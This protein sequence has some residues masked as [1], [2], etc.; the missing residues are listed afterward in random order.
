MKDSV[1]GMSKGGIPNTVQQL[2]KALNQIVFDPGSSHCT[3]VVYYLHDYEN[4][5]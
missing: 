1:G 5:S 3:T 2:L 4:K